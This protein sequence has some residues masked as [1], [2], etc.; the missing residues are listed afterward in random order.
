MKYKRLIIGFF[1]VAGLSLGGFWV[2]SQYLAPGTDNNGDT[3]ATPAAGLEI[4]GSDIVMIYQCY[5]SNAR[6]S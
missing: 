6:A 2:Y 5:S 4:T 3:A 1:I